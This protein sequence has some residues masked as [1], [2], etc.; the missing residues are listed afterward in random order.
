MNSFDQ[1]VNNM[2]DR[3]SVGELKE[4]CKAIHD[5]ILEGGDMHAKVL[6]ADLLEL[7]DEYTLWSTALD[8]KLQYDATA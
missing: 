2:V 1:Q 3:Y 5:Q 4:V 8:R 6:D 7:Q